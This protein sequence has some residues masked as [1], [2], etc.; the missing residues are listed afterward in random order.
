MK[1]ARAC[2]ERAFAFLTDEFGYRDCGRGF[3]ASGFRLRY[4]G[5]GPGVQVEW[6]PRD[7]LTV[8]L[9]RTDDGTFPEQEEVRADTTLR[10]FDL[11]DLE[12]VCGQQRA[13]PESDLYDLPTE[14]K[15]RA[16]AASLR[17]CGAGLLGGDLSQLD[18]MERRVKERARRVAVQH[19]GE[20]GAHERGW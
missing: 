12:A 9:V 4:C 15:A 19:W 11:G 20:Q 14:E 3:R 18:E 13:V 5:P 17:E 6:Y 2:V 1:E 7:P 8:W 10:Y 16:L